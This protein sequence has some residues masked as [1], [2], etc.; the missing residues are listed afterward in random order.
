LHFLIGQILHARMIHSGFLS[1]DIKLSSD[2][3]AMFNKK[4]DIPTAP[5]ASPAATRLPTATEEIRYHGRSCGNC[6]SA[7]SSGKRRITAVILFHLIP[8]P[9]SPTGC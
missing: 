7:P 2:R 9:L 6:P 8:F 1:E 3:F 5:S 4:R